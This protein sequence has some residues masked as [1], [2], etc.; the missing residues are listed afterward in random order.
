MGYDRKVQKQPVKAVIYTKSFMINGIVHL[1][2]TERLTDLLDAANKAFLPVTD[3]MVY[4][5][6]DHQ[7]VGRTKFLSLNK[8]EI[9]IMYTDDDDLD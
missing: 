2:P 9:V 6:L 1:L 5:V 8:N 3:A 4:T 7:I